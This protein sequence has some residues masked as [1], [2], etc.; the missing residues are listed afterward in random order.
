MYRATT[1]GIQVTVEPMYLPDQSEP[2]QDRYVW[3]YTIEIRNLGSVPVQLRTRHW[4]ITDALGRVEEVE[5]AGVIGQQPLILPGEAFE[6]TSGCP[7]ATPSGIMEGS[8]SM[9]LP[10]G[11]RMEVEI[12]AFSLDSPSVRRVLN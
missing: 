7:L 6:Y 11:S 12:P 9:E 4:I 2:Q 1:N 3:A 5:G 8:Y 10:D